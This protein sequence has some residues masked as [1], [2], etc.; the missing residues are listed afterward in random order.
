MSMDATTIASF[1]L[2]Y[3]FALP[4]GVWAGT[5]IA[6]RPVKQAFDDSDRRLVAAGILPAKKI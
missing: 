1:L 5:L 2:G 6:L 3:A 4:V